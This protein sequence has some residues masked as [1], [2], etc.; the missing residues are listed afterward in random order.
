MSK[1]ANPTL[2]GL[3]VIGAVA[4]A[5]AAVLVFGSGALFKDSLQAVS[6]FEGSVKGLAPGA[7]V[8]F[9]GIPVGRVTDVRAYVHIDSQEFFI[10]VVYEIDRSLITFVGDARSDLA[11]RESLGLLIDQGLRSQLVVESLVTGQLVIELD[12]HPR[13]PKEFRAPGAWAYPEI[14]SI[15]TDLQAVKETM[16]GLIAHLQTVP[17]EE[18]VDKVVSALGG[19]EAL[20]NSEELAS[21][22]SGL[23]ELV[24]SEESQNL[25]ASISASLE[26]LDTTLEEVRELV[27]HADAQVDPM[28]ARIDDLL[29][30]LDT[31]LVDAREV[32]ESVS[33]VTGEDSELLA[34]ANGSLRQ[35]DAAM[36]SLRELSEYLES[37]PEA[38]IRG[39]RPD[40]D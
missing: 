7:N 20:V 4:I 15:P 32:F 28:V 27:S 8:L 17:F 10:P 37:H 19:L 31:T 6:F 1:R 35:M 23:D 29:D 36:R 24:N 12:F 33:H 34:R 22:L 11:K 5:V 2:I 30:R 16:E 25:T 26:K 14:P 3:F 39:K 13:T 38:L 18:L 40:G 21:T 9:R